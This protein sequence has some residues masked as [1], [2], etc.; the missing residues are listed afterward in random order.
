MTVDQTDGLSY[1]LGVNVI[2]APCP[3]C[4]RPWKCNGPHERPAEAV[5]DRILAQLDVKFGEGY[6]HA[7]REQETRI[8]ELTE[9]V[10]LL[11]ED[12]RHQDNRIVELE[13]ALGPEG[14]EELML[15]ENQ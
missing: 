15:E 12:V 13:R 6:N 3:N 9:Q 4:V 14:I 5:L 7:W 8:A 2:F 1:H 10:G 11:V